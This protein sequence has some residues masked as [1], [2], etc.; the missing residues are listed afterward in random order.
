MVTLLTSVRTR[1]LRLSSNRTYP[2]LAN[3]AERKYLFRDVALETFFADG[4]SYLLV[5][6]PGV[7]EKVVQAILQ[8][9]TTTLSQAAALFSSST[10]TQ[11]AS[12]FT[13]QNES[14]NV[15]K[16]T[17]QWEQR[18][19]SNFEYLMILNYFAGRTYNDITAYPVFPWIIADWESEQLDLT[20][21]ETFRILSLPMGAQSP[22]RRGKEATYK[23]Y[24][25]PAEE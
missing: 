21:A 15:R 18:E 11:S 9:A 13:R 22:I 1:G 25:M 6:A 2:E 7:R 5:F 16:A 10:T 8:R 24:T 19:I 17:K 4:R 23:L 3:I 20:K 14:P 12:V